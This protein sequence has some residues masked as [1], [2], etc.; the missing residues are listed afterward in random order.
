[1]LRVDVE[2]ER[3]QVERLSRIKRDRNNSKVNQTL[4]KLEEV[5]RSKDNTM[6]VFVECVEVY[7]TLGEMCDVLRRVFGA[8]KEYLVF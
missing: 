2:H 6:P 1:M 3:K 7:A 4:K 5:A 8:Q